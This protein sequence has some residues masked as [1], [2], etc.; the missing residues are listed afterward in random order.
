MGAGKE[1]RMDHTGKASPE[2]GALRLRGWGEPATNQPGA[3]HPRQKAQQVQSPRGR[4]RGGSREKLGAFVKQKGSSAT[5]DESEGEWQGPVGHGEVLESH[6]DTLMM[7]SDLGLKSIS[8]AAVS[9]SGLQGDRMEASPRDY[10]PI[11]HMWTPKIRK[12]CRT[13]LGQRRGNSQGWEW[14]GVEVVTS[15]GITPPPTSQS[16][17]GIVKIPRIH[18]ATPMS[19]ENQNL[20]DGGQL[21]GFSLQNSPGYFRGIQS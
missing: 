12:E 21:M 1:G 3:E 19:R 17:G 18:T 8:L 2:R 13:A 14:V 5:R 7:G 15:L 10:I 16:P 4:E 6:A 9:Q 11:P 20:I